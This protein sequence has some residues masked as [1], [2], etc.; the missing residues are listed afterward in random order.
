MSDIAIGR[1]GDLGKNCKRDIVILVIWGLG[2]FAGFLGYPLPSWAALL[3]FAGSV[4]IAAVA[5]D[6]G[7]KVGWL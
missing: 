4:I 3:L 1:K 6:I 2:Y 5:D 7:K